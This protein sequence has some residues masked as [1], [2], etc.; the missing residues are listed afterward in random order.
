MLAGLGFTQSRQGVVKYWEDWL[1]QGAR[2]EAPE[3]TVNDL[4]RANLWHAL[5]LPRFRD[6]DRIDLPYSNFAYGQTNAD[7]PINQAVYVDYMLYGLRG[8]FGVAEEEFAAMYRSQQQ[9]DGRVGGF[10][11]WGVYSPGMLYSIAQNFLLSG[12][13]ASFERLLPAS[14]QAL[15]WCLGEVARGRNSPDA[16]GLIVA[17]LNDLN[18]DARAWAFPNAYFVA[19]L[20]LF[21]RALAAFG[22]PPPLKFKPRLGECAPTSPPPSPAPA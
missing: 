21:A 6:D 8:H 11:E 13:R 4:F 22:H 5:M 19:G 10:A 9:P 18:K 7:W 12:D 20:D 2:F 17:P 3:Q 16:P 14:L 1:S 15:D